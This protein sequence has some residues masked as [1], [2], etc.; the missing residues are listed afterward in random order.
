MARDLRAR[1]STIN[2]ISEKLT[3]T[4]EAATAAASAAYAMDEHRRIVFAEV[5]RLKKDSE[6]QQEVFTHKVCLCSPLMKIFSKIYYP[7]C[8]YGCNLK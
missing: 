2:D 8:S 7:S 4:A 5:E 3:E 1:D 6:K